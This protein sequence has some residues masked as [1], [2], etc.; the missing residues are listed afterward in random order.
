MKFK[1]VLLIAAILMSCSV[2]AT[3]IV[4]MEKYANGWVVLYSDHNCYLALNSKD[5]ISLNIDNHDNSFD[6][7]TFNIND[8]VITVTSTNGKKYEYKGL[9]DSSLFIESYPGPDRFF[10]YQVRGDGSRSYV[11]LTLVD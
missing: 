6:V 1:L 10:L 3:S 2:S 7:S 4:K 11:Q 9:P 5:K 8:G